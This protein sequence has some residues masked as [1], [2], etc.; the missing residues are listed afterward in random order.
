MA[1]CNEGAGLYFWGE[2]IVKEGFQEQ[3]DRLRMGASLAMAVAPE[4][5][6]GLRDGLERMGCTVETFGRSLMARGPCVLP[7][8]NGSG[9]I[10]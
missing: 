3:V 9:M 7:V 1:G 8:P 2:E 4:D 6:R 5:E 10:E